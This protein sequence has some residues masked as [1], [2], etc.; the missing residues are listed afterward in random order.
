MTFRWLFEWAGIAP[1]DEDGYLFA[2]R[3]KKLAM[4]VCDGMDEILIC[5]SIDG[6]Y[7]PIY[8]IMIGDEKVLVRYSEIGDIDY[9]STHI[10]EYDYNGE[11]PVAIVDLIGQ[12]TSASV[13]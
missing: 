4:C 9:E 12:F 7:K 2:P 6:F 3:N 1:T 10:M 8:S 13:I 5:K 11:I